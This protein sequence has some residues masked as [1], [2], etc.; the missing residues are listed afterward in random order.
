MTHLYLIR[1]GDYIGEVDGKMVD[2]GLSPLGMKQ[3]ELLRDRLIATGEIKADVLISS[4]VQRARHT[5][6]VLAP[7]LNLPVVQDPDFEEWRN[8]DGSLS[9]EQ[10]F[11]MWKDVPN[12]QRPY[13][14]W[15][16]DGENWV[17]FNL[18]ATLAL[19][20]LVQEYEGKTI[21]LVCHG[22]I[23]EASFTYF[24]DMN[25]HNL[26]RSGV[27]TD[28]TAIT[29]WQFLTSEGWPPHW[30]LE[31]YNDRH[32]LDGVDL[33]MIAEKPDEASVLTEGSS[34]VSVMKKQ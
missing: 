11:S 7:A 15:I 5:A 9:K 13:F 2:H 10:F 30:L 12:D 17:E 20:R 1:H 28:F 16:P 6:K 3:A 26:Q 4:T 31:R 22:G 18:R 21:V 25:F 24:F 33:S 23:V 8:E 19:N 27:D 32:H 34:V 14:R 29:H